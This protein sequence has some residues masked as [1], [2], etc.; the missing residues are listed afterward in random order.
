[1]MVKPSQLPSASHASISLAIV[2]GVP[3]IASPA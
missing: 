2:A 3:T 1:M